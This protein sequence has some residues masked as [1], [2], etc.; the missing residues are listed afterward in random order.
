MQQILMSYRLY[1]NVRL[2]MDDTNN[3][4]DVVK[5][6]TPW[7]ASYFLD[8]LANGVQFSAIHATLLSDP[9]PFD[10]ELESLQFP[11]IV[12]QV[13]FIILSAWVF[14]IN[15]AV[16]GL[17]L[18]FPLSL[19]WPKKFSKGSWH[20]LLLRKNFKSVTFLKR[21]STIST[22]DLPV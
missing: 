11:R 10:C 22:N 6:T 12:P 15:S 20:I 19:C 21:Y 18:A 9:L 2:F 1:H 13:E 4:S 3:G 17:S 8:R 5:I 14:L 7:I 16:F